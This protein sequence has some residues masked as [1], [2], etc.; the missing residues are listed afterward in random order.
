MWSVTLK[1]PSNCATT[2]GLCCAFGKRKSKSISP[3]VWRRCSAA[4]T[5]EEVALYGEHATDARRSSSAHGEHKADARRRS[6]AYGERVTDARRR[7]GAH[8]EHK[9][10]KAF[11]PTAVERL[12]F[13]VVCAYQACSSFS[14][15]TSARDKFVSSAITSRE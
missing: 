13:N 12:Y 14:F 4:L 8:G 1:T 11:Y 2:A 5:L 15:S 3:T 7:I 9:R 6:G 10:L